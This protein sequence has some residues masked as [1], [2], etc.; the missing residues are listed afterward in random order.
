MYLYNF[1]LVFYNGFDEINQVFNKKLESCNENNEENKLIKQLFNRKSLENFESNKRFSLE[2]KAF[3][4]S[5]SDIS[6]NDNL[7]SDFFTINEIEE[8]LKIKEFENNIKIN[9]NLNGRIEKNKKFSSIKV[10]NFF[11]YF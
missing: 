11:L 5:F 8:D 3:F 4:P 7:G 10:S 2:S 6:I 9:K 1:K